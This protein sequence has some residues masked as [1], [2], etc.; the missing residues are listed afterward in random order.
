MAT[1]FTRTSLKRHSPT[2][3]TLAKLLL[4]AFRDP[5]SKRVLQD[6]LNVSALALAVLQ[7]SGHATK[8]CVIKRS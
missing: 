8:C 7:G 6:Q 5:S 2:R 1:T 3:Q 4:T